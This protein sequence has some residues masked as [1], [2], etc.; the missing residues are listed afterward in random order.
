MDSTTGRLKEEF[1]PLEFYQNHLRFQYLLLYNREVKR[2][3]EIIVGLLVSV[4]GGLIAN[5]ISKRWF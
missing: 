5:Y 4:V 3:S 1:C 2:M